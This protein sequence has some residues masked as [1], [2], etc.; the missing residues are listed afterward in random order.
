MGVRGRAVSYS[1]DGELRWDVNLS[2]DDVEVAAIDSR[3][4][5][6]VTERT[7]SQPRL[8]ALSDR[9][10]ERPKI[11][12]KLAA[13]LPQSEYRP[14]D[15]ANLLLHPY[16]FGED[17]AA[18]LCL[19]LV[20]P[21]GGIAFWDGTAWEGSPTPWFESLFL[22]NSFEMI[23]VPL[24]LGMV[25]EGAPEGIYTVYLAFTRPGTI[26]PVS[27]LFPVEFEVVSRN[28]TTILPE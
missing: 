16:N 27:E 15:N 24:T 13:R 22:P 7:Y 18:D 8:F 3:G 23:D 11:R 25:P 19:A 1:P 2:E 5:L 20:L 28:N 12:A 4:T 17:E 26:E 10:P 14:G 9:E 21:N 6:Y